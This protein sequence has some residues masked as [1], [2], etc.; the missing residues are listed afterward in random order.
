MLARWNSLGAEAAA[1]E[2]LP[3]CG[4]TRWA[5]ELAARRPFATAEELFEESDWVWAGLR[6]HDWREA[7][8]SH[9][10]IG[11]QHAHA[12]TAES[13]AWSWAEQRTAMSGIAPEDADAKLALAERNRQYEERFGRIFIVCAA[14]KSAAEIL[15]LLDARMHNP[16]ADEL[17]EAAEQQRQI[18]QLR[19]RRWLG[20]E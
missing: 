9:P 17:L 4:S 14:G 8:E 2:V 5:T 15:A 7:F 10:R 16:A 19:L 12:A 13:L 20:V 1:H 3:C 6:E 11:Q 18:T